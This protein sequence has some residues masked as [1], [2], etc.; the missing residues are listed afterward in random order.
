M[1][2]KPVVWSNPVAALGA[3]AVLGWLASIELRTSRTASR[4]APTEPDGGET[5]VD[6]AT[7]SIFDAAAVSG[8][9]IGVGA[10]VLAPGATI[11]KRWTT[12]VSGIGLLV[13]AGT[14]SVCA[15]RHLG[16]YHRNSLTIHRDQ[17]VVDTGPYR[18]V[19]H[20]L[21]VATIGVAVGTGA[22]L[23]NWVSLFASSLPAAALAHRLSVEERMLERHLGT[24]YAS[25]RARTSRLAPG[26]W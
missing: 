8:L 14:L 26:I 17:A 21:Y 9:L 24:E 10:S 3:A 4:T 7:G 13:A 1:V 23:G 12:F 25:Y 19:R 22:V 11:R 18:H 16:H 15:R 6:T 5:V 20:P 2:V